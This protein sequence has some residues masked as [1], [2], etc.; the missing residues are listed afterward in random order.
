MPKKKE[1]L[2]G[3]NIPKYNED[4]NNS[5]LDAALTLT[6]RHVG[7]CLQ[8]FL[9]TTHTEKKLTTP[10]KTMNNGHHHYFKKN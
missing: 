6:F 3:A 7:Y 9:N 8:L 10:N 4:G 5:S 1:A 2:I